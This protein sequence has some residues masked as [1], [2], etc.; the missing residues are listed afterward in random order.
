MHIILVPEFGK[1][2]GYGHLSRLIAIAEELI[3]RNHTYCFHVYNNSDNIANLMIHSSGLSFNCNCKVQPNFLLVDTYNPNNALTKISVP[4]GIRLIQIIDDINKPF[5]AD[6][7]IEASPIKDWKPL[8]LAAPILE[9]K[10][11]PILRVQFDNVSLW[12]KSELAA[13]SKLLI[14]LGSS[15]LIINILKLL[16][17]AIRKSKFSAHS[18][19]ISKNSDGNP[20]LKLLLAELGIKSMNDFNS[21]SE[22]SNEF[23]LIISACGVTGW[24]LLFKNS[25][26]FFIGTV[27]NQ[28]TQLDYFIKNDLSDGL[29]FSDSP[30]FIE[31]T[32]LKLNAYSNNF[33]AENINNGRK[34]V[35]DWLEKL[36]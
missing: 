6:G 13:S 20:E 25:P 16:V 27:K 8:N 15:A 17:P 10:L 32:L 28:Q 11:S 33:G 1:L 34:I 18:L 35:V 4:V 19:Y 5:F 26:C 7:Y 29:M 36:N 22:I 31:K 24:E 14:T 30:L 2:I 3:H 21:A 12:N 9:F 23:D